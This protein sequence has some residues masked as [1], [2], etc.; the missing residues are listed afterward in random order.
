MSKQDL[1]RRCPTYAAFQDELK[2]LR[3]ALKDAPGPDNDPALC[4]QLYASFKTFCSTYRKTHP[5][6]DGDYA[7]LWPVYIDKNVLNAKPS[8]QKRRSPTETDSQS[9]NKAPRTS[10]PL[11]VS[12]PPPIEPSSSHRSPAPRGIEAVFGEIAQLRVELSQRMPLDAHDSKQEVTT[13]RAQ[14]RS[15]EDANAEEQQQIEELTRQLTDRNGAHEAS[16]SE[17]SA[18]RRQ[19][20]DKVRRCH[21][22]EKERQEQHAQ[23]QQE[24]QAT[25]VA[26]EGSQLSVL[27]GYVLRACDEF[28]LDCPRYAQPLS[29]PGL[30]DHMTKERTSRVLNCLHDFA[31]LSSKFS[32][33]V[34]YVVKVDSVE[35]QL[36]KVYR[37]LSL[38]LHSDKLPPSIDGER[39]GRVLR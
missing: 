33:H 15:L 31:A 1:A 19:F 26:M 32:D 7:S 16:L 28:V 22:M 39:K 13:L 23:L 27:Q 6:D 3:R 14:I 37:K 18:L 8:R 2:R 17:L 21:Q 20:D 34:Q 35:Q 11:P 12:N 24:Q 38:L 5:N 4:E 29:S 36:Q 10:E 9:I 30:L 25:K